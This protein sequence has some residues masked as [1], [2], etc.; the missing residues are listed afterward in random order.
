MTHGHES[1]R[2]LGSA[3]LRRPRLPSDA[4]LI[5]KSFG[6]Y[7]VLARLG[8]VMA[9]RVS[10]E[11]EILASL[12]YPNIAR[13][14]D[15]GFS[16]DRQPYLALEYVA[17]TPFTSYCDNRSLSLTER[18]NLFQQVLTAV[19]PA[20]RL[21]APAHRRAR[22]LGAR[23]V[24]PLGARFAGPQGGESCIEHGETTFFVDDLRILLTRGSRWLRADAARS[25]L[26]ANRKKT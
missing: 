18:L 17:G 3:L 16:E 5:G 11:R 25:T 22:P 7:R 4:V 13:L 21:C 1:T 24:G 2:F 9:E 20:H 14:L 12:N 10:R 26:D 6:P 23:F 8:R 15:A 19:P